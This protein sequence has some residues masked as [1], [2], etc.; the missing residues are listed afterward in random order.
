MMERLQY[1]VWLN[2]PVP[3]PGTTLTDCYPSEYASSYLS[4]Q[5]LTAPPPAI[6]PLLCPVGYGTEM[7]IAISNS[8]YIACCPS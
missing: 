5:T 8:E 6:S 7:S 2:Y 3:V 4:S 1:Q